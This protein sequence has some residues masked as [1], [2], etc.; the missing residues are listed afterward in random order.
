M[1]C[2]VLSQF[3]PSNGIDGVTEE[4]IY[5]SEIDELRDAVDAQY[6]EEIFFHRLV[7]FK[8]RANDWFLPGDVV[9]RRLS[10]DEER[11]D[12]LRKLQDEIFVSSS[13][14]WSLYEDELEEMRREAIEYHKWKIHRGDVWCAIIDPQGRALVVVRNHANKQWRKA[15]EQIVP[16]MVKSKTAATPHH[17]VSAA[18]CA[19]KALH[20]FFI[21]EHKGP[22]AIGDILKSEHFVRQVYSHRLDIGKFSGSGRI[23][24]MYKYRNKLFD[25]FWQRCFDLL[26]SGE[27]V[28]FVVRHIYRHP[29]TRWVAIS[30]DDAEWLLSCS[31]WSEW[32]KVGPIRFDK[33][34]RGAWD[35]NHNWH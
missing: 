7:K 5:G 26:E 14:G 3:F 16:R 25:P 33:F 9:C 34:K 19:L 23:I 27:Q 8:G 31:W 12:V 13:H 20:R 24:K 15:M 17:R 28:P 11:S 4:P 6:S 21:H 32:K 1:E 29:C 10:L 35:A 30:V 2:M 18:W 22:L